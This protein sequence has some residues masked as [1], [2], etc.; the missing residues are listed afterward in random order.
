MSR[1]NMLV[2]TTNQERSPRMRLTNWM[3]SALIVTRLAWRAHKLVSS[4]RPTR[5]DSE[6]SCKDNNALFWKR[7]SRIKSMEIWRTK[8]WNGSFRTRRSV[9]FWYLR[10]SLNATVP[11]RYLCGL[12]TPVG[13]LFLAAL[14]WYWPR[15]SLPPVDLFAV[16]LVRAIYIQT[17]IYIHTYIHTYTHIH[18]YKVYENLDDVNND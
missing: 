1:H 10:I 5:Y 15:G 6:A 3:S 4:K 9:D 12:L 14:V 13:F 2:L 18:T 11:G 16:C 17:Y 8:F 7:R